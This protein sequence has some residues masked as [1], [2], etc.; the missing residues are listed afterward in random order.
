MLL[1][2]Y[3]LNHYKQT[4]QI[5]LSPHQPFSSNTHYLLT[6]FQDS[7]YPLVFPLYLHLYIPLPVKLTMPALLYFLNY[8]PSEPELP[9][10]DIF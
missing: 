3:S 5:A 4:F 7:L 10:S 6:S 2:I 8:V 1:K 9:S